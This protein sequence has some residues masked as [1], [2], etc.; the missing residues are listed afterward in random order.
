MDPGSIK[1]N[2][3]AHQFYLF[4]YVHIDLHYYVNLS[5]KKYDTYI[6]KSK[7]KMFGKHISPDIILII[8]QISFFIASQ[9]LEILH[10]IKEI[11]ICKM[12]YYLPFLLLES[13]MFEHESLLVKIS[14]ETGERFESQTSSTKSE[15]LISSPISPK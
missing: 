8:F 6:V 10:G 2:L 4:L 1:I 15:S 11:V 13:S 12:N 7:I 9:L 14:S 5:L 3:H